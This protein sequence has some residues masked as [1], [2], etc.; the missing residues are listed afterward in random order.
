MEQTEART[1]SFI[2]KIWLEETVAE[3]GRAVWRGGRFG[4]VELRL[5][6]GDPSGRADPADSA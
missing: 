4:A 2:I 1:H 6:L 5:L 3:D